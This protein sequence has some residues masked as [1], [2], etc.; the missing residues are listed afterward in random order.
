[1]L[2]LS[3]HELGHVLGLED[4][5]MCCKEDLMNTF[6]LVN[7]VSANPT[8]LDLYALY[9]LVVANVIPSYV[10]LSNSIPYETAFAAPRFAGTPGL[11]II[12]L[13]SVRRKVS[14]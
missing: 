12:A 11:S 6:P 14:P 8:T 2:V 9:V 10:W 13:T 3:S 4:E 5:N 7:N 1:L